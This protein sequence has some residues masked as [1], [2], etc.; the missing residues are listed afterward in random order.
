VSSDLYIN[1]I[2]II[3]LIKDIILILIKR[4]AWVRH[5]KRTKLKNSDSTI[6]RFYDFMD[7]RI[8]D[9]PISEKLNLPLGSYSRPDQDDHGGQLGGAHD[10]GN[11][12][13]RPPSNHP[14][15]NKCCALPAAAIP[16]DRC[17]V[18]NRR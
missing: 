11:S 17:A 9:L 4:E 13:R 6:L 14:G 15:C 7:L 3:N 5:I 8:Y 10:E 1:K 2:I 12:R 16:L 18:H